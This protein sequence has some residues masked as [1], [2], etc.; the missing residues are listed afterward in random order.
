MN[1]GT[2]IGP[3]VGIVLYK[4]FGFVYMFVIIGL[5]HLIFLPLMFI[6]MPRDIDTDNEETAELI[7]TERSDIEQIPKISIYTLIFDPLIFLLCMSELISFFSST[8]YEPL[9]SFRLAE[10]TDSDFISS[11]MFF[12]YTVG[13]LIMCIL[14]MCLQRVIDPFNMIILGLLTCGLFN[15]LV[16]PS[17]LL[18]N[19]LILLANGLFFSGATMILCSVPQ[20]SMMANH[21]ETKYRSGA[22]QASDSSSN[23]YTF[24]YSAGQS[25]GPIC[26]G[27]L[28]HFVGYRTC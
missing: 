4:L 7:Q 19:S 11:S 27:V 2:C 3:V 25:L 18:P 10:L 9:L 13:M 1:L 23:I 24:V 12:L 6:F 28:N 16:G 14:I 21:I 22:H 17:T 5:F 26:G 15:F 8:Y 20:L